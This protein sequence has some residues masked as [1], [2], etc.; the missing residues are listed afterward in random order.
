MYIAATNA[1]SDTPPSTME[2]SRSVW[3]RGSARCEPAVGRASIS[4]RLIRSFLAI[5]LVPVLLVAALTYT[6]A[7]REQKAEVSQ[8]LRAI[9]EAK[10]DKIETYAREPLW[11]ASM[12]WWKRSTRSTLCLRGRLLTTR[13]GAPSMSAPAP[14]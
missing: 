12:V 4:N 2:V 14:C 11:P 1:F 3:S 13:N 9:A 5:G 10:A 6:A 8:R 7:E